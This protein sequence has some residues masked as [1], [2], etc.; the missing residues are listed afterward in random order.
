MLFCCPLSAANARLFAIHDG[1]RCGFADASGKVAIAARFQDCG[2]F[3]EGLAPVLVDGKWG[4]LD[5]GGATVI[6]PRFV[7]ADGFSEG[8]AFVTLSAESK[9]VID[10]QGKIL[11]AADYH[12][13]GKFSEGLAAVEVVRDWLC[14]SELPDG[15]LQ[16]RESCP[17]GKGTPRDEKWGYIDTHGGM[18]IAPSFFIAG[19][20]H[21]GLAYADRGFI[22][23]LGNKVISGPFS[24]TSS[25]S[26]GIA[27][28]QVEYKTWGYID[29]RGGWLALPTF[30]EAGRMEA[31]RGLVRSGGLYGY[32]DAS[33]ALVIALQFDSALPFSEGRAAVRKGAK[34]G[35]IG[36]TGNVEIPL[37][38]DAAQSFQDGFAT[39]VMESGTM[40]IDQDGTAVRTQAASLSQTFQRLQGFEVGEG[41]LG[42][43]DQIL[44]ILA[45][46]KEQLREIAVESLKDSEGPAAAKAAIESKLRKA[47]IGRAKD[48]ENRPY[49]LIDDLE[50]VQ[51]PLQPNLLSVLFHL[52]LAHAVDTS[53]SVFQR[54]GSGW[55]LAWKV[56]RNDYLKWELDAYHVAPPQFTASDSNGAFLML[57]AA[58]SGRY[59]NGSYELWGDVYRVDGGF[60][61]DQIFH[62]NFA[63]KDHQ[64]ALDPVGLRLE[65]IEM[66][67]DSSLGGYRVFPYRYEIHGDHVVRVAPIG[68]NA[69]D[70]IGEWGNLPWE[71]AATWSAP[72]QLEKIREF[73]NKLRTPDGYFGGEFSAVQVCDPQGKLWQIRFDRPGESVNSIYFQVERRDQWTFIVQD[74]GDEMRDGCTDV[75][76]TG[77]QPFQTMFAKP[78][79]W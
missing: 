40:V 71:E 75:N 30:D 12:E 55:D 77:R 51:P 48:E 46:Y 25:F 34:W 20:F 78:L 28:V 16:V 66:A 1:E 14:P 36:K 6:A 69:H 32:V 9:V 59:A 62:Q 63:C 57:V 67:T 21:D 24:N 19:Q 50:V 4:Y 38:F 76:W 79:E 5:E 27:A 54:S 39:V 52:K 23:K 3:A 74:I 2:A 42:P 7:A 35:Y 53:L 43:L 64:V 31:G 49:G 22:D 56:D 11:F 68:F 15:S 61:R 10:R 65:T 8:L 37:Q 58:D 44:P 45:V 17:D 60:H 73:Y 47:G 13:H 70:F 18:A 41:G 26:S 29:K 72:A 33:G